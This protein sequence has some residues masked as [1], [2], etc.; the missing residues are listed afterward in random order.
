MSGSVCSTRRNICIYTYI[1]IRSG[2]PYRERE[3]GH[4]NIGIGEKRPCTRKI[5][6]AYIRV[7]RFKHVKKPLWYSAKR[8][9]NSGTWKTVTSAQT[10]S[11]KCLRS[12]RHIGCRET[13][14]AQVQGRLRSAHMQNLPPNRYIPRM[15]QP[16][17]SAGLKYPRVRDQQWDQVGPVVDG[18]WDLVRSPFSVS[19]LIVLYMS[20]LVIWAINYAGSIIDWLLS[21]LYGYTPLLCQW[22]LVTNIV[23]A[24][25]SLTSITSIFASTGSWQLTMAKLVIWNISGEKKK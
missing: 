22:H 21:G 6:Y 1:Y 25:T 19:V 18:I 5:G 15:L 10:M 14:S 7:C 16:R 3:R 17:Q 4:E 24:L 2:N 13:T 23:Q 12:Q 11:L 9:R 8:G 20:D